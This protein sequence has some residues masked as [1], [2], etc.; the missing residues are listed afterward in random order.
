MFESSVGLN[1]SGFHCFKNE[2]IKQRLE[3][4]FR[5]HLCVL[6]YLMLVGIALRENYCYAKAVRKGLAETR[7]EKNLVPSLGA[8]TY[9]K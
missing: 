1:T 3:R 9:S 4:S 8:L 2:L 5:K 6:I 7:F